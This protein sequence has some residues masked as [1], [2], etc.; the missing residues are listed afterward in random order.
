MLAFARLIGWV[1]RYLVD[2]LL[3]LF[4]A[5]TLRAGDALRHLQTGKAQDY[6]YG[7]AFGFLLLIVWA[8]WWQ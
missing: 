7:A 2:G 8:R 4:S 1:D 5:W 3:N 6:V